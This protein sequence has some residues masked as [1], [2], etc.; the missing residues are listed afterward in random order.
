MKLALLPAACVLA[1]AQTPEE[2]PTGNRTTPPTINSVSPLGVSRGATVELTVEGLNLA[3]ADAVHF[4]GT[5][6]KA[7]ILR[8]KELPDLPDI[9]LGSNGTLSTVD[10]GPLPPRN[11]VT[12]EVDVSPDAEPGPVAFRLHTPLGTSPAATFAVEPYYGES[13]D[14]E[15]NDTPEN[16]FESYLPTILVGAISRPGDL[17][18]FK[19]NVAA[20]QELVFDNA[21]NSLGSSLQP[22]VAILDANQNVLR[23]FGREGG[24]EAAV[25]SYRFEKAGAHYVRVA[26]YLET[27]SARHFYRIKL[28]KLPVALS[29]FPLG[30]R[31]GNTAALTLTG[32]NVPQKL[33]VKGEPSDEDPRAVFLRPMSL[34]RL[35]V[36]L[37]DEPEVEAAPGQALSIPVTVNGRIGKDPHTFR[38]R[39]RKGEELVFEVNAARLGSQLDSLLEVLDGKGNPIERATVRC[40]LETSTTLSERDSASAGVRLTSPAGFAVGDYVMIGG[41]IIRVD[42]LPRT[43]DDD[44]IF[45][46]FGGQRVA[47]FGTSTEAH[48]V[49][50]P[51]YRVQIHPPGA[52]FA[53][54]GLPLVRLHFRNDD[55]GPGYGKDSLLSFTAP[56]E[57]EYVLRLS[58]VRGHAGEECAY[59]LTA[60]HP[61]P[62]FLLSV[63]PRNPN[64]PQGGRIPITVT[65][66]RLDGFNGAIEVSGV[67]LPPGLEASQGVIAPGQV[68]TTLLLS[69]AESAVLSGAA[70]LKV[71]GRAG[72]LARWANPEDRLKL[73]SLMPRPDIRMHAETREVVL[74]PGGRAEIKVAIERNN[75]FGGR[76]PVEVRN[77]PPGVLVLDVGLNGVLINENEN[78]RSFVLQAL[79]S[80]RPIEQPIFV[81]GKIETRSDAQQSSYA[82]E[83]IMLKVKPTEPQPLR[84]GL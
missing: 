23:E 72:A 38:F 21:G 75:G 65:A 29:A 78:E 80:A 37:G 41:E 82:G 32:Y 27:G 25:F 47:Y 11:Q 49:D 35:K 52:K 10:L 2:W 44:F 71:V 34:N 14:R 69:A 67:D 15:P 3:G 43:P 13:P 76:V 18:F 19:V 81:S 56:A 74:Q 58:D 1:L 22:V 17:D 61:K 79:P 64:V 54:N 63:L 6:I 48:A 8:I 45:Q 68:S 77:L 62:D 7:R 51:V 30:V 20:G 9:R 24:R 50:K 55:G 57:G 83:P 5:G 84:S 60:R 4:S 12:L 31:K 53:P 46:S 26:D 66:L 40:V 73:I 36:A 39:A 28:G 59:R 33:Q 16:A 70:P 42:A